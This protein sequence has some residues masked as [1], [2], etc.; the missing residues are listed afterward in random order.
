M[1]EA[2]SKINF[3][4]DFKNFKLIVYVNP[5]FDSSQRKPGWRLSMVMLK[6]VKT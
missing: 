3:L 5:Y 4:H 6:I 1:F 2:D